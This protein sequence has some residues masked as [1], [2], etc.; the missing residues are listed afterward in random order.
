MSKDWAR[1]VVHW[2]IEAIDPHKMRA[3]YTELFNWE[4]GGGHTHI[5]WTYS[6]KLK[7]HEFPGYLGGFGRYLFRVIFLDR[8]YA[9]LMRATLAAGKASAEK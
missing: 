1:P 4:I 7:D 3:F 6:F 2:E 9:A 5:V 8:E